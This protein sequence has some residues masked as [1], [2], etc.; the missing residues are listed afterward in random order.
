MEGVLVPQ[1]S[2]MEGESLYL[3]TVFQIRRALTP[4]ALENQGRPPEKLLYVP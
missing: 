2:Q 4:S 3:Q 1:G